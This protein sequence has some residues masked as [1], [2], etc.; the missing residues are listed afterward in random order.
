MLKLLSLAVLG[1][2]LLAPVQAAEP[3]ATHTPAVRKT[4]KSVKPPVQVVEPVEEVLPAL[5]FEQ[6]AVAQ[7]VVLGKVLC[8]LGAQVVISAHPVHAGHFVL[9]LGR[10]KF[11]MLPV[12]TST[13]AV[14]LEDPVSGAVW[15]QLA[16]K[17]MLM[18]QKLG[19]RLADACMNA[20]QVQVA[21]AMERNPMPG[22]LDAPIATQQPAPTRSQEIAGAVPPATK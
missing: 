4:A 21:A 20:D 13:G 7:K 16:N 17:S 14:R 18:N 22:L 11:N 8:E 5:T 19:R 15:L 1:G 10:Q 3:A 9:E 2:C 12:L 6:L